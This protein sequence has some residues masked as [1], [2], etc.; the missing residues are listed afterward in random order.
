MGSSLGLGL[1]AYGGYQARDRQIKAEDY[2]DRQRAYGTAQMDANQPGL[3]DAAAA[4]TA[5]NQLRAAQAK[6][7]IGLLPKRVE[8]A[9]LQLGNQTSKAETERDLMPNTQE[10]ARNDSTAKLAESNQ[11]IQML[12]T[13]LSKQVADGLLSHVDAQ[14][15]LF[16]A[17]P[18]VAALGK[19]PALQ[20]IND[21][22][23]G[24]FF[25]DLARNSPEST[26]IGW[27]P[28]THSMVVT[29]ANGGK[30][31]ISQDQMSKWAELG[32][33]YDI[34]VAKPGET[35]VGISP[36]GQVKPLYTAP[37]SEA[38]RLA[39]L[40]SDARM[41]GEL[42]RRGIYKTDKE[43][44]EGMHDAKSKSEGAYV[45]SYV[46]KAR[47][48]MLAEPTPGQLQRLADEARTVY[49]TANGVTGGDASNSFDP[50]TLDAN[51][52]RIT[53]IP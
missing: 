12:P 50:S 48:N 13:T 16:G 32:Q 47:G 39:K 18:A 8:V 11:S 15:K 27:D 25:G 30:F 43:A 21:T 51:Q 10:I 29:D 26:D 28:V 20:F 42:V 5:A 37:E 44:W 22:K 52:R 2:Q 14:K 17:F 1:A 53:G 3:E 35:M 41:I 49:R 38:D 31:N 6:G 9:G 40:P 46:E 36:T 34:K 19:G 4:T 45:A 33:K 24:G 23:K 7:E